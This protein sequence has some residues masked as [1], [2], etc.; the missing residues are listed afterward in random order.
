VRALIRK[1]ISVSELE[2]I[3]PARKFLGVAGKLD[4]ETFREAVSE[5]KTP[6]GSAYD[7][8]RFYVGDDDLFFSENKTW[9][10]SNQWS[11][12]F[13]PQLDQLM[14]KYPQAMLSYKIAD[15]IP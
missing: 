8:R 1:G 15:Q 14:V 5:M 13:L 6:A 11:I 3:L 7:F 12:A 2:Q 9:A 10:L 4:G